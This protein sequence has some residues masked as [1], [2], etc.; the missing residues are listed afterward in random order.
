[1][2]VKELKKLLKESLDALKYI[3][4][5]CQCKRLNRWKEYKGFDYGEEHSKL[6][7]PGPGQ[8]WKTPSDYIKDTKLIS[9]LE[10]SVK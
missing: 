6:G 2:E 1:M 8:R 5:A 3:E 9:R 7:K 4:G 10:E